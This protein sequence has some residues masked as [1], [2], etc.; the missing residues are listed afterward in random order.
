MV[1]V[2]RISM[3]EALAAEITEEAIEVAEKVTDMTKAILNPSPKTDQ[4][5]TVADL[6]LETDMPATDVAI[7]ITMLKVKNAEQERQM[8]TLQN[9]WSL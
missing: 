3:V 2:V 5:M 6:E 4:E 1:V 8:S 9:N 7:Q